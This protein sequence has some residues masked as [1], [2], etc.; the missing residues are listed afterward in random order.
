MKFKAGFLRFKVSENVRMALKALRENKVRSLL[1]VIGVVMGVTTL[2]S[3]SA[4]MVG[5]EQDMRGLLDNFGAD[6]LFVYKFT[7]GIH[8]SRPTAEERARK[9]LNYD[10]AM[11]LRD[12][13][14]AVK[15]VSVEIF[16]QQ[17][18]VIHAARYQ[19]KEISG[20]NHSGAVP[21]YEQVNNLS[22][23]KGRFFSQAEDEH[24]ADVVVIGADVADTFF[25]NEDPL[26]KNI[27]V[28]SV[29]YE[30]IGVE[31]KRKGQF[32]KNQ[33]ADRVATVPY[34]SYEKHHPGNVNDNFIAV[35]PYPGMKAEAE[36]E[37]REVL[38]RRRKV[39]YSK[40]DTFGISSTDEIATQF[41]QI[42][43]MTA[44]VTFVLS[45]IGLMIGGVG[46][47]NIMLMSVTE[48]TREI[49]VRKAIGARRRDII[50]QFLA[51]A[52]TLTGAG[53][54]IGVIISFTISLLVN[55]FLPSMP[56]SVP[57]WAVVTGVVVS[58]SVGLFF[59]MYP[60]VKAARL[61]PVEALR[62]E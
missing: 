57:L 52:I 40:P 62:Y 29:P 25:A 12:L 30:V 10:D 16:P 4:I 53:G 17:R 8:L 36:D 45:S 23:A 3:V 48:R 51:E 15:W 58:M 1:T 7:P 32:F 9:P 56:S 35:T 59:G 37:I 2:L 27:L 31:E 41:H 21:S 46:V 22:L 44:V 34:H 11:A 43:G 61:D 6:T 20:V 24:R 13:C 47:M 5:L 28:D 60:A 54:V 38:R 42:M 39:A 33:S 19:G 14:P 26:G 50:G 49:G 55:L 18:G